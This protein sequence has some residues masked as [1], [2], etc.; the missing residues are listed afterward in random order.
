[1]SAAPFFSSFMCHRYLHLSVL[2][3]SVCVPMTTIAWRIS[4]MNKFSLLYRHPHTSLLYRHP[5]TLIT[6]QLNLPPHKGVRV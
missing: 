2:I 1:M 4:V 3:F 6:L 5:H